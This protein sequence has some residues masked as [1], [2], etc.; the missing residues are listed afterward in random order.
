MS[1]DCRKGQHRCLGVQKLHRAFTERCALVL[2][3]PYILGAAY[4][5]VPKRYLIVIVYIYG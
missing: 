4:S 1:S 3:S 2:R 5:I